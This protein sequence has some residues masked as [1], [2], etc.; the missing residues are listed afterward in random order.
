[1]KFMKFQK[2]RVPPPKLKPLPKELKYSLLDDT[3]KYTL[4]GSADLT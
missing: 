2:E 4:I 1:M 3:D